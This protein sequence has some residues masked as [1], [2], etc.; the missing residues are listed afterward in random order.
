MLSSQ[1]INK[2]FENTTIINNL[3]VDIP[4]GSI[5]GLIGSNGS[6]KSTF[7]RLLSGVYRPDNGTVTVDGANIYENPVAKGKLFFLSDHPYVR[8]GSSMLDTAK[9]YQNYYPAFN[10]KRFLEGAEAFGLDPKRKLSSFSKGMARQAHILLA[11]SAGTDY[12]LCDES[13][14]G[15]DPVKRLGFK[16]ILADLVADGEHS[17]IIS[18]HNLR[19]L[20]TICDRISFLH[21]GEL[22]LDRSI[23]DISGQSHQVQI[24]FDE[25]PEADAFNALDVI[26]KEVHGRMMR[27]IIRGDRDTILAHC[28]NL[29]PLYLE[30]LP[31]S[32]ED[33]FITEM[34]VLGYDVNDLVF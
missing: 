1:G 15:L 3:S 9:F 31:L 26:S 17:V 18:S 11:L 32:L 2:G 4:R 14:D 27:L 28:R 23:D 34:E 29:R 13:F 19:E 30:A 24:A 21:Q 5:F 10:Q 16:R 20:E 7:L 22:V 6:G 25:L 8:P 12:I 33:V